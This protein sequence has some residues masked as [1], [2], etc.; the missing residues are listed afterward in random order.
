MKMTKEQMK[1]N[2]VR[3]KDRSNRHTTINVRYVFIHKHQCHYIA[4]Q[5]QRR[6]LNTEVER[7]VFEKKKHWEKGRREGFVQEKKYNS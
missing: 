1:E 2:D 6:K 4:P 5:Q 7:W 3:S